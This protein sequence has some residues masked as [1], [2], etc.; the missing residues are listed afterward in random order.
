MVLKALLLKLGVEVDSDAEKKANRSLGNIRKEAFKLAAVFTTGALAVGVKKIADLGSTAAETTNVINESFGQAAAGVEQWAIDTAEAVNR[1]R[2]EMREMAAATGAIVEPMLGSADAAAEMA[3]GVSALAVDLGSFFN[4]SDDDALKALQAGLIGS[5]EP[6]LKFGVVMK[7]ANLQTFASEQGIKKQVKE[8]NEAELTQL[9]YNFILSKTTKA[10]GDAARTSGGFANLTKGLSASVKDLFTQMGLELLPTLEEILPVVIDLT[11]AFGEGLLIGA[12][13]VM[14]TVKILAEEIKKLMERFG[15]LDGGLDSTKDVIKK[16]GIAFAVFVAAAAAGGLIV[17][18][19][20][21]IANLPLL[22][23][24]GLLTAV[25]GIV[26]L[27]IEDFRVWQNGGDSLIGRMIEGFQ[28]WVDSFGGIS[29]ALGALFE[30]FFSEILGLSEDTSRGIVGAIWAIVEGI[31]AFPGVVIGF[32]RDVHDFVVGMFNGVISFFEKAIDAV[33]GRVVKAKNTIADTLGLGS[34]FGE[35]NANTNANASR[36]TGAQVARVNAA[37]QQEAGRA[38]IFQKLADANLG[39]FIPAT[40][41]GRSGFRPAPGQE[42]N[43]R[44]AF[45]NAVN[46]VTNGPVNVNVDARGAT[47]PSAI[48]LAVGNGVAEARDRQTAGAFGSSK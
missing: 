27:L 15:L 9:R 46:S 5:T 41:G 29:A 42:Q 17:A 38:S 22:I 20:W 1:S 48:G 34:V 33:I 23:M 24:I 19:S 30:K 28:S 2:F 6:L 12:T 11:K 16:L 21:V 39:T 35:E 25:V 40:A 43:A 10:Q 3:T 31:V 13:F 18:A 7:Q 47:D 4:T 36:I 45:N 26:L 14:D 44:N 32:F 8:L 37:R